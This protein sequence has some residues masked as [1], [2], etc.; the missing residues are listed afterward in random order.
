VA[1]LYVKL[2]DRPMDAAGAVFQAELKS[3]VRQEQVIAHIIGDAVS[4]EFYKKAN[5]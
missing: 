4:Q 5:V 3:G 2:L 1:N